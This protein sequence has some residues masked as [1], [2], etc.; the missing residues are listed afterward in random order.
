MFEVERLDLNGAILLRSKV[1]HDTRGTFQKT[2]HREFFQRHDMDWKFEEQYF[3]TSHANVIRGLHFQVPPHQHSKLVYCIAGK[4]D[5]VIVDIRKRSPTY[6]KSISIDLEG[7]DGKILYLPP[8]FAHGFRAMM[9]YTIISYA[10][11]S[12]YMPEADTGILWSSIEYDW[13][14]QGNPV[15]S[16][17][18]SNFLQFRNFISPF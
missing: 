5:D 13:K 16:A 15:I 1:C 14:L 3:T 9:D 11:T 12:C 4:A 2:M 8:G 10:V 6:G 7:G 17:R 18:D